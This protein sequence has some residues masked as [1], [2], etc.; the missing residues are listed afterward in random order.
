[1]LSPLSCAA[2]VRLS[3]THWGLQGTF[4]DIVS[5]DKVLRGHQAIR[6]RVSCWLWTVGS[7]VHRKLP[8]ETEG[9]CWELVVPP[10]PWL[11]GRS[12]LVWAVGRKMERETLNM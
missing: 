7:L 10:A 8:P 12:Q 6:L 1:M 4:A 9:F 2:C 3:G 5:L 11:G